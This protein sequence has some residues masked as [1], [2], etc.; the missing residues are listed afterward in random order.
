MPA[1]ISRTCA[2]AVALALPLGAL[3]EVPA[4]LP[5][6]AAAAVTRGVVPDIENWWALALSA[7]LI[8][9]ITRRRSQF[10]APGSESSHGPAGLRI[11][12]IDLQLPDGATAP[13]RLRLTAAQDTAPGA[14]PAHDG[15][16]VI[17]LDHSIDAVRGPQIDITPSPAALAA[18]AEC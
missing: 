1:L 2:I 9:A 6:A 11:A 14:A 13:A 17:E 10:G 3:A 4:A 8:V 12:R 7:V 15:D 18:V 16:T 5:G